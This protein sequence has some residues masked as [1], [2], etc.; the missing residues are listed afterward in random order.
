MKLRIKLSRLC[1]ETSK[2]SQLYTQMETIRFN[3]E[4]KLRIKLSRLYIG[5]SKLSQFYTQI[6]TIRFN[7]SLQKH[8]L[9]TQEN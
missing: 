8:S 1:T 2:L 9:C 6:E 4:L 3:T 5:T 7:N